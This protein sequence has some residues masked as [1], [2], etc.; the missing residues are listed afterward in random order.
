MCPWVEQNSCENY[1]VLFYKFKVSA[2]YIGISFKVFKFSIRAG[3]KKNTLLD[4]AALLDYL[5]FMI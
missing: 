1:E 2:I 3:I 5:F 4:D